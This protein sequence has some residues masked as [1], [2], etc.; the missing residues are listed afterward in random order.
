MK[1][2]KK[3]RIYMKPHLRRDLKIG[4]E[5]K[6]DKMGQSIEKIAEKEGFR[7]QD[8]RHITILGGS[9]HK[10]FLK[11]LER[12][13]EK[14]QKDL[15]NNIEKI[16]KSLKW[17]FKPI[18]GEIYKVRRR[19]HFDVPSITESRQSYIQMIHMPDMDKF[20]KKFNSILKTNFPTPVP[21]ITLFTKGERKNPKYYGIGISSYKNFKKMF[22]K[23][24]S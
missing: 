7:K 16:L 3:T 14:E 10:S 2:K 15:L 18:S 24:V 11:I 19:G 22:P 6:D 9:S 23:K 17:K 8:K 13:S 12:Y 21:H 4:M 1:I 20:Y 5:L